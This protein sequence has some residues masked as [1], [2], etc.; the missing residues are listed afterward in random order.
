MRIF[1]YELRFDGE[2]NTVINAPIVKPLKVDFQDG[3]P[4]LWA[5]VDTNKEAEPWDVYFI[6]TGWEFGSEVD[7]NAD[8][9]HTTVESSA[10]FVWHWFC[11]KHAA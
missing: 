5:A 2:N 3:S 9:V 4:Y 7:V 11:K 6:G 8:Y 1:K 10:P